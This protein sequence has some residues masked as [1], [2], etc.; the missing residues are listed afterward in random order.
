M[1]TKIVEKTQE[2]EIAALGKNTGSLRHGA[3]RL[4]WAVEQ[5][6]PKGREVMEAV[7]MSSVQCPEGKADQG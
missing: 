6:C 4:A 5:G 3:W 1:A 2:K 7:G